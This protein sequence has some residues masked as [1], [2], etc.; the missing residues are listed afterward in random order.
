MHKLLN[1]TFMSFLEL[2]LLE[3]GNSRADFIVLATNIKKF[4]SCWIFYFFFP[5]CKKHPDIS[6]KD[7]TQHNCVL[8][9]KD[10]IMKC[11]ISI[12]PTVPAHHLVAKVQ[13][14]FEFW[15]FSYM[16]T[17]SRENV[18]TN[19]C[20]WEIFFVYWTDTTSWGSN[21]STS[22]FTGNLKIFACLVVPWGFA[23]L[24]SLIMTKRP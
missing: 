17:S 16:K 11:R 22:S 6:I 1:S 18:Q 19:I 10:R 5:C 13:N 23:F 12:P 4:L 14:T 9:I 3:S 8:C 24:I 15:G 20:G 2:L 7:T 21:L